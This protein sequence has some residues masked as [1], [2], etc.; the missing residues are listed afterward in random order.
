VPEYQQN[1]AIQ[2]QKSDAA[3]DELKKSY[4]NKQP[5][6]LRQTALEALLLWVRHYR[7]PFVAWPLVM[8]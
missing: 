6:P 2:D 1:S 7:F 5:T 8:T 3:A 4:D